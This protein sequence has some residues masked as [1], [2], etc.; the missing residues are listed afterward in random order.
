MKLRIP[1]STYCS[2]L[3]VEH[4]LNLT[5]SG[6]Q[7]RRHIN[8]ILYIRVTP[9]VAR[10]SP[11]DCIA[12]AHYTVQKA[13]CGTGDIHS[14]RNIFSPG[15]LRTTV[16][17]CQAVNTRRGSSAPTVPLSTAA[18]EHQPHLHRPWWLHETSY[19]PERNGLT[20]VARYVCA[21]SGDYE[22]TRWLAVYPEENVP[23]HADVCPV[24]LYPLRECSCYRIVYTRY[25]CHAPSASASVDSL[26]NRCSQIF[27]FFSV[28]KS[29]LNSMRHA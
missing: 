26:N 21:R 12:Y 28:K 3:R 22:S 23:E 14:E 18:P 15:P 27:F 2:D 6:R 17:S 24:S 20:R 16:H 7:P 13:L 8:I 5:W 19:K 25:C 1:E 10:V 11:A 29:V 9:N 4:T